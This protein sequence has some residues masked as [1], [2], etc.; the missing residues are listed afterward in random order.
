[1]FQKKNEF[2]EKK[3]KNDNFCI[4]GD[5]YILIDSLSKSCSRSIKILDIELSV[6]PFDNLE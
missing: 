2:E 4:Y 3:K 6:C 5:E 1:M